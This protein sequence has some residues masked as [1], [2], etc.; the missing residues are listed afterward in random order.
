MSPARYVRSGTKL[1][2]RRCPLG[3]YWDTLVQQC[4]SCGERCGDSDTPTGCSSFCVSARCKVTSAHYYDGLLKK[5]VSCADICGRHPAECS[6]HCNISR[7]IAD[8]RT[9]LATDPF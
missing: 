7:H 2:G 6:P 8:S 5:C 3:Q 9:T 4:V 1:P